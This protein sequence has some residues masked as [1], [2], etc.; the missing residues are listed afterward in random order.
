MTGAAEAAIVASG[1][2]SGWISSVGVCVMRCL[3][4]ATASMPPHAGAARS[5][6]DVERRLAVRDVEGRLGLGERSR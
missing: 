6:L 1:S 2:R 3:R 4:G 5:M